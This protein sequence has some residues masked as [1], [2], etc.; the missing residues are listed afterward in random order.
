MAVLRRDIIA[1]KRKQR[2]AREMAVPGKR[3]RYTCH[4][5]DGPSGYKDVEERLICL[6]RQAEYAVFMH[7]SGFREAFRYS[8]IIEQ[9]KEDM[10]LL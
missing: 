3:Y 7:P 6:E 5:S 4:K 9:M 2:E 8:D 10:E 1:A